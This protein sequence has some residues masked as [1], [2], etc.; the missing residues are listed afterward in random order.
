MFTVTAT[1]DLTILY[2]VAVN[3]VCML[4]YVLVL[5]HRTRVIKRNSMLVSTTIVDYFR[6]NGN[7]VSVECIGRAGG[8]RFVALV[9]SKPSRRFRNSHIIELAVASYVRKL[10]GLDLEKIYWCFP[11]KTKDDAAQRDVA[12]GNAPATVKDDAYFDEKLGPPTK[13]PG[14][15]VKELSREKFDEL[16]TSQRSSLNTGVELAAIA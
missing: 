14:Y 6:E 5:K 13:P 12:P 16:V 8:Q 7:D 10:R 2:F 15:R 1:F 3:V 9:S 11:V 4:S